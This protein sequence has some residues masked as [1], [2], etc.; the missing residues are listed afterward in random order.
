MYRGE[1]VERNVARCNGR[2]QGKKLS[3]GE[4]FSQG[5]IVTSVEIYFLLLNSI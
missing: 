3:E 5:N 4:K 1:V 2:R